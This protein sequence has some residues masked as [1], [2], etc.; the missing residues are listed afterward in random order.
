MAM[1]PAT[2]RRSSKQIYLPSAPGGIQSKGFPAASRQ[3][4]IVASYSSPAAARQ[5]AQNCRAATAPSSSPPRPP[6]P[7]VASESAFP[8]RRG[9]LPRTAIA[10]DSDSLSTAAAAAANAAV[11]RSVRRCSPSPL[12]THGAG[13]PDNPPASELSHAAVA[14]S[15]TP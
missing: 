8:R 3:A 9:L 2:Q 10:T 12:R 13:A 7:D 4:A 14:T 15:P 1:A 5:A 6:L 11:S